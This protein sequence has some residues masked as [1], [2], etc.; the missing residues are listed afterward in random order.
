MLA[1][2]ELACK[3]VVIV[4]I[5]SGFGF[6]LVKLVHVRYD[7]GVKRRALEFSEQGLSRDGLT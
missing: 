6:A 7:D 4:R 5:S 3:L 1:C 2:L